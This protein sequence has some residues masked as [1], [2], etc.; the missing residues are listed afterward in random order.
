MSRGR[1][2]GQ[3]LKIDPW[4]VRRGLPR[5][6]FENNLKTVG[7]DFTVIQPHYDPIDWRRPKHVSLVSTASE[8]SR[9]NFATKPSAYDRPEKACC[10]DLP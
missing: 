2:E 3:T 10:Y 4:I 9:T 7:V 5:D 1:D 8:G 6:E